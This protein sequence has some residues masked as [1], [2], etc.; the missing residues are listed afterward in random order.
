MRMMSALE[1]S[2]RANR[3]FCWLP[4]ESDRMGSSMFGG[5]DGQPFL[6]GR[7]QA[8]LGP[9]IHEPPPHQLAKR[10]DG[11]VLVDRPEREHAV[12]LPVAGHDRDAAPDL[13]AA[14]GAIEDALAASAVCPWPARPARPT[15]SPSCA[16]RLMVSPCR[17]SVRTRSGRTERSVP[18]LG[19]LH[20]V[21]GDVA[22]RGHQRITGE[23]AGAVG[24][25]DPPV[26]HDHDAVRG[27]QDLRQQ[28]RDEDD[29]AA[30]LGEATHEREQLAGHD[31]VQARRR[32]VEDDQLGRRHR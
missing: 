26:T 19:R 8:F 24:G 13:G 29:G 7:A 2:A 15:I 9:V 4:P 18:F 17:S 3:A 12:V 6:P 30:F 11:D 20:L 25:H 23:G 28:V 21:L 31:G 5:L 22:H 10:A 14:A 27:A 32:L 1:P 16:I